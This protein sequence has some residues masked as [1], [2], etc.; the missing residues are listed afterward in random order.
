MR[1]WPR[2]RTSC[3]TQHPSCNPRWVFLLAFVA[4]ACVTTTS[5]TAPPLTKSTVTQDEKPLGN[6]PS[7]RGA[8]GSGISPHT[9]LPTLWNGATNKGILWKVPVPLPG[10]NSPIIWKNRLFIS[11]ATKE[12]REVYCFDTDSGKLLWKT[13]VT[14]RPGANAKPVKTNTGTGYASSTM[15]TDGKRVYAIFATGDLT[16]LDFSGNIVW[17]H[18]LGT[19]NNHYGHA[20]SLAIYKHLLISQVDQGRA[21]DMLSKLT[22]FNG[23]TGETVWQVKRKVPCSWASPIVVDHPTRPLV[24]TA[25]DPWVTAYSPQTGRE[26]WR[27]SCLDPAEIGPSPIYSDGLVFAGNEYAVFSAIRANG[28]GDVSDTHIQWSVDDGLP[29]VCSPLATEKHVLLLASHGTLTCYNKQ[30]GGEPLWEEEFD[31][32]FSTSPSLVGNRVYLFDDKGKTWIVQPTREKCKHI[33]TASLG[34]K[35]V[36]S[37]AFQSGR[38][39]IRGKVHLFCIGAKPKKVAAGH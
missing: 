37:P 19:P 26:I 36:T 35:C 5:L 32:R 15:A 22:A 30:R 10:N 11:G 18:S 34:E 1:K 7:F 12:R 24:I 4:M 9:N 17:T 2:L 20:S 21:K 8:N 14:T 33:A 6:W 31:T 3:K 28:T 23:A 39:Y 25:A 27:A 38:L 16:A 13:N 29:D